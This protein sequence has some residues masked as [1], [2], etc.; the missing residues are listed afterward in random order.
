MIA[1][2]L[3]DRK[4]FVQ[5]GGKNSKMI[6]LRAGTIQGSI[7][8]A[9]LFSLFLAPLLDIKVDE[10]IGFADDT[11]EITVGNSEEEAVQKCAENTT[12]NI[13]WFRD[14]G[15]VVNSEKTAFCIFSRKE[16]TFRTVE[17]DGNIIPITDTMKILGIIFDKKFNWIHQID[18]SIEK[19]NRVK[20]GIGLVA[21]YLNQAQLKLLAVS[22]FYSRL[23]YGAEVW[24][25]RDISGVH[26]RRIMSVSTA[27]LKIV[28]KKPYS[29]TKGITLHKL[30]NQATPSMQRDISTSIALHRILWSQFPECLL[31]RL[32][33]NI[34][35]SSRHRGLLFTT[36]NR[37]KIGENS[38]SNRVSDITKQLENDWHDMPSK[39]FKTYVHKR[40]KKF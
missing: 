24:M 27:M 7:N 34:V 39:N 30:F 22:L 21:K 38:L 10:M 19:A 6:C 14:S 12:S 25:L 28:S 17:V 1:T 5:A 13:K 26:L 40:M 2:W 32:S 3:T 15:M 18:H 20:Q 9:K 35:E 11:D 8:G 16:L 33:F 23:Y 31:P 36:S 29:K 4:A 37:T